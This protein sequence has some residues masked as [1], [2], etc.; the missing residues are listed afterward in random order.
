[1]ILGHELINELTRQGIRSLCIPKG[2]KCRGYYPQCIAIQLL[3]GKYK[4]CKGGNGKVSLLLDEEPRIIKTN[5]RLNCDASLIKGSKCRDTIN[6][7]LELPSKPMFIIDLALWHKHTESEKNEL[8]E[9]IL[10]SIS[11]VREYLWDGNIALTS[12][13]YEF[14]NYLSKFAR[15]AKFQVIISKEGPKITP[16][17]IFLDPEG[18]C[19]LNEEL[20]IKNDVFIIGG[21]VDKERRVKGESYELYLH[22]KLNGIPRCRIEL[23]ESIVGVPDRINKVIEIILKTRYETH[24]LEKAIIS[25]MSKRDRINRLFYELQRASYTLKTSGIKV[26]PNSMLKAINW[27]GA[28]DNELSIAIKKAGVTVVNDE[29]FKNYLLQGALKEGPWSYKYRL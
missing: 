9:Q 5:E 19:V 20:V 29:D 24:N 8:V 7:T 22:H 21:I 4:L 13:N 2:F 16:N 17:T 15:N 1:M 11:T 10:A 25:S 6:I 26:I 12:V 23:R 18:D 27:I 28:N 14:M 3:I